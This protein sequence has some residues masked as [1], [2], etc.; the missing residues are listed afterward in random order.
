MENQAAARATQ[1]APEEI[2][3]QVMTGFMT[4]SVLQVITNLRIPDHLKN[5]PRSADQLAVA[6]NS[7]ADRLYRVLRSA[8]V[9]GLVAELPD[10]NFALTPISE[11]LVS[12]APGSMLHMAEWLTEPVHMRSFGELL[13]TVKTGE[14]S[15]RHV[16]GEDIWKHFAKNE[17]LSNL[18]HTALSSYNVAIE[19]AILE[20]YDFGG[21]GTLVEVAGGHGRLLAAILRKHTDLKGIL[22]DQEHVIPGA[23]DH[24]SGEL[25]SRCEFIAG[26]FFAS[27]P[28][29]DAILMKFIIH[30]WQD[31]ECQKIL[32]NCHD[33]LK[34]SRIGRLMLVEGVVPNDPTP[35]MSKMMDLE[36]M[37]FPNGRER[38]EAEFKTLL[39]S[40]GF[41]LTRIVATKC[42]L[43]VIEAKRV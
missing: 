35:H 7:N 22:F 16:I 13:H 33:A 11:L 36:M 37:V 38:T 3:M 9:A 29:G 39:A 2:L 32:R 41:E 4:S 8:S 27:V 14:P 42:P 34:G 30:D 40:A 1:P 20:A 43:S 6:T 12:D 25:A 31:A 23:S 19:P 17:A 26:D 24:I 10:R 5:G 18:F 15:A 28:S 21:L